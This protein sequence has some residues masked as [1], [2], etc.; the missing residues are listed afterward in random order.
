MT[1]GV[2]GLLLAAGAGR[3]MG[4]PKALLRPD[5]EGPDAPL[6]GHEAAS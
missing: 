3:R 6:A 2:V 4:Q 1:R 5:P